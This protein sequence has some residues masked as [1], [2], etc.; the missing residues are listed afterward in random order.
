MAGQ[1]MPTDSAADAP[2]A[3]ST[4]DFIALR[5][6]RRV[7]WVLPLS[8]QAVV[9]EQARMVLPA[10]WPRLSHCSPP[11]MQPGFDAVVAH[12]VMPHAQVAEVEN[13]EFL[14]C[15]PPSSC[16][17]FALLVQWLRLK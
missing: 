7:P 15:L 2:P 5:L 14:A 3:A 12:A 11:L 4:D 1:G 16:A 6:Q 13:N 17:C 9:R 10:H 8:D